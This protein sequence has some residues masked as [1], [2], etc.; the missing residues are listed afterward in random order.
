MGLSQISTDPDI[1][2]SDAMTDNPQGKGISALAWSRTRRSIVDGIVLVAIFIVV[3]I[4]AINFDL[5][6]VLVDWT[7]EFEE[8]EVDEIF[9][10]LV[11]FAVFSMM[12]AV[13]RIVDLH[14]SIRDLERVDQER[15]DYANRL[16]DAIEV[17]DAGFALYDSNDILVLYNNR[18]RFM[19]PEVQE[20][21]KPGASYEQIFEN[22]YRIRYPDLSFSDYEEVWKDRLRARQQART[23]LVRAPEGTWL[24]CDDRR[25]REG[26]TVSLR[27]DVTLLKQRERALI[28]MA[29]TAERHAGE[30]ADM[31]DELNRTLEREKRSALE[32][33]TANQAKSR[34]LATMSH[35]LRTP[36]N[37]IIGFSEII[38][39]RV[40]GEAMS[41]RYFSYAADIH[42]SGA[43]LLGIINDIL[44][45][46]RIEAGNVELD[47][48]DV[49]VAT[50]VR[51]CAN[52][53]RTE[54]L[55]K[56]ISLDVATADADLSVKADERSLRQ[57][58]FNLLSNAIKFT[59]EH[60]QVRIRTGESN[61]GGLVI[62]IT[63]T[64]VGIPESEISRLFR[65]FERM[66]TGYA[67][68]HS[69]AGLGLPI[70]KN[71]MELHGGTV[72]VESDVGQGTTVS[73]EFPGKENSG[74][75][76]CNRLQ[77]E[78]APARR[79]RV[80]ATA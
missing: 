7:R 2:I 15:Q 18:Y 55:R 47:C 45:I 40:L 64:G 24:K 63:D 59:P 76:R 35:E 43:H 46:S 38:K 23:T 33:E 9:I 36:L 58:L 30:L 78:P 1:D 11:V 29:Q 41:D 27:T 69:G 26:G 44:D 52:L 5:F 19:F 8:F 53:F 60:G 48:S 16:V 13:R 51:R 39:D 61:E 21:I 42:E 12:F 62:R 73:I 34:F 22:Y 79:R 50:L 17:I 72:S 54:L 75:N 49:Q 6:E 74:L 10:S 37:A 56:N 4:I 71:L 66:E 25:T 31:A 67:C 57:I 14:H 80:A 65:P 68:T 32:A 20:L 28:E 3:D 77:S 70:V